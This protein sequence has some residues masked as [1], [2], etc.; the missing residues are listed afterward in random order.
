MDRELLETYGK[1]IIATTGCPSGEVQRL[2]QRDRYD[3]ACQAAS[4]YRDIFGKDNFFCELMDHGIGIERQVRDDLVRLEE[5][6]RPARP[7]HQRPALHL[8]RGR[9][10]ARGAAVRAD[11]QDP[12][13]PEPVQVRRPGLLP[14]VPG[15]DAR[16]VGRRVPGG[17]RQ[18]PADR[19][20]GGR[21]V[22]RGPGPDAPRAR[23]RGRERGDLA[24]QGG[25]AGAAH[26]VP[27]RRHRAVPQAGRVRARRHHPDG[28]PRLLP[29]HRRP[30]PARQEGR[31]PRAAPAAGRRP[32]RWSPTSWAS[33]TSTRSST[34]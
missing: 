21:H 26:A 20:A 15:R 34:S 24:G 18:H 32:A 4:D 19:R 25:R 22:H 16:P 12:G 2:L 28:L 27:E 5:A 8:R 33:P 6:A 3:D 1:G 10:A 17:L 13:R 23:P 30:H 9:Q 11:R 29:G 14:Q 7:G 31:H